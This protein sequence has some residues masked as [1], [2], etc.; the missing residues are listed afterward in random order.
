MKCSVIV[1]Y[2]VIFPVETLCST[3]LMSHSS[4]HKTSCYKYLVI[5]YATFKKIIVTMPDENC[6]TIQFQFHCGT[7]FSC[8]E[9]KDVCLMRPHCPIHPLKFNPLTANVDCRHRAVGI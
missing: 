5:E 3:Q 4:K 7:V 9:E 6:C 1:I 8:L 2:C